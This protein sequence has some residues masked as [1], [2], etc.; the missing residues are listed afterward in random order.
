MRV[1]PESGEF[2]TAVV[3][4]HSG[5]A[6]RPSRRADL[7]VL[8]SVLEGLH[9][10]ED[11]VDVSSDG[12]IVH[13]HLTENTLLVDDV[14]SSESDTLIVRVVQ[15]AAIIAGDALGQIGDHREGHGSKTTLLTRLHCVL[16]MGELGVDGA[17][18]EL[19]ANSLELSSLVAELADLRGAHESEVKGPEEKDDIL[20]WCSTTH[21]Q[22]A[23]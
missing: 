12:E 16:S 11:L 15:K 8:I 4:D 21:I 23:Q 3:R 19:A 6:G 7:T 18:D 9:H 13:A 22:L 14:G 17:T 1:G 10:A 2:V 20:A 5:R